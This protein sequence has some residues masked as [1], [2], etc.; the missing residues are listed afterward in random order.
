MSVRAVD[1]V[2]ETDLLVIGGGIGGP[3]AA[4][5]ASE[6][7]ARVVVLEKAAV[8]RSGA[9]GMGIGSWHQMISD[10]I[11]LDDVA[12]EIMASGGKLI[13]SE[14]ILPINKGL[15]D[16]NLNYIG[17]RDNWDVVHTLER[18]GI[19]MTWDDGPVQS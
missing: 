11:T 18:W 12:R 7:G 4:L 19:K 3:F 2:M 10:D 9:T 1:E 6:A 17:Y 8:R 15:V 16:E 5:F 14:C 13:G